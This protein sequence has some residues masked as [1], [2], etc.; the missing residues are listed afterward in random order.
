MGAGL[1]V[2]VER[3]EAQAAFLDHLGI[4][5]ADRAGRRVARVDQ[6]LVRVRLVVGG[7]GRAQH[8]HLAADLGAALGV[9]RVRDAVGE[10]ADERR[11]VVAR[12]AVA[13]RDGAGE[14]AVLVHEREAEAVELGHDDDGLAGEALEEGGDLLG[15]GGL[16]EAEHRTAV[17]D[18][19]VQDGGRADLLERVR[20]GREVGVLL[21]QRAQLVLDRVVVGVGHARLAAVV[22]VAQ[23]DD[24]CRELLDA[25]A[26]TRARA[27]GPVRYGVMHEA[28]MRETEHGLQPADG[29]FI[30]NLAVIAWEAAPAAGRGR[31]A[32]DGAA[33]EDRPP[34]VPARS[35]WPLQTT[36]VPSAQ[37]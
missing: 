26:G 28:K 4:L 16:L 5:G 9:D 20:A 18:G 29:W 1:G 11:H 25:L 21:D 8:H 19:R 15:L 14:A 31:G 34:I 27:H 32:A 10:G 22:R 23:L 6:R 36:G 3:E 2:E 30:T 12:G 33:Y 7:E 35:P 24:A 17:A 37:G 13:A